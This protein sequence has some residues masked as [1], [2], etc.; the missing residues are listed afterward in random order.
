MLVRGRAGDRAIHLAAGRP[1]LRAVRLTP[2]VGAG[3][4]RRRQVLRIPDA[5]GHH[6]PPGATVTRMPIEILRDDGALAVG[7]AVLPEVAGPH[8]GRHDLQVAPLER[9]PRTVGHV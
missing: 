5:G 2:E 7:Y 9:G 1:H 4:E 6:E 3:D 8:S